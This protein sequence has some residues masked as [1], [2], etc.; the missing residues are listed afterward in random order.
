MSDQPKPKFTKVKIKPSQAYIEL[1]EEHK[2]KTLDPRIAK[3]DQIE[4]EGIEISLNSE[5]DQKSKK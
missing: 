1:E 4:K 3:Q 2:K 5:W